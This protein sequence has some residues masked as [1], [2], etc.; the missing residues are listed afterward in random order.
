MM[1]DAPKGTA[2]EDPPV[3]ARASELRRALDGMAQHIRT[4]L[5]SNRWPGQPDGLN[6]R[7]MKDLHDRI[8]ATERKLVDWL[9]ANKPR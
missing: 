5:L 6:Y 8:V 2:R 3:D 4:L 1:D 9:D 7:H